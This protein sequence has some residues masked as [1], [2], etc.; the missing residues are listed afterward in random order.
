MRGDRG[1]ERRE[2]G[3]GR[4][5]RRVGERGE[6]RGR[7]ERRVGERGKAS[8]EARED[9]EGTREVAAEPDGDLL[10]GRYSRGEEKGSPAR[11]AFSLYF[12]VL[13]AILKEGRRLV[14]AR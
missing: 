9:R 6:A 11:P 14:R 10:N 2:R 12:F 7:V 4:I 1:E 13:F 5:E 8:E 3:H